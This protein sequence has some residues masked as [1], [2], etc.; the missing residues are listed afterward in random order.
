MSAKARTD[1]AAFIADGDVSQYADQL[2]D[3]LKHRFTETMS[4]LRD[5]KFQELLN[6]YDR[7]R[8]PF[9]VAYGTQDTVSSEFV[10]RV[11]DKQL[12]P[13]DYLVAF[14]EFVHANKDKINALSILLNNPRQ[15]NSQVLREIRL[16]LRKNAFDEE[17]VRKAHE[18]SGHKALADIISLIKNADSEQNP[19]L[20]AEERVNRTLAAIIAKHHFNDEQKQWLDYIKEHLIINLAIEKDNFD[21]VPVLER[22]GGLVK[23]QQIFGP[24]FDSIIKEINC[25]LAA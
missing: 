24:E 21:I 11:A 3:N 5:K 9:Y 23:A 18:L 7:A 15:W 4:I 22:H 6:N 14:S 25:K 2:K 20:T 1:F 16:E 10:F 12:K 13:P 17:K 8:N 19:L